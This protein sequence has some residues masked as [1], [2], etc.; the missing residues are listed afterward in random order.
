MTVAMMS[1]GFSQQP[2]RQ[3]A[4]EYVTLLVFIAT[5]HAEPVEK[6][7]KLK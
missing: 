2:S 4:W 6:S 7:V 1:G 3:S 5:W